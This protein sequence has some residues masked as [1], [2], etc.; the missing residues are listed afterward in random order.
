M[1]CEALSAYPKR[2]LAF[3]PPTAP[4]LEC[5]LM[6]YRGMPRFVALVTLLGVMHPAAAQPPVPAVI[7]FNRDIRP[8]LADNC[9]QCHGP[10]KNKRK[11][12]LRLDTGEGLFNA[13]DKTGPVV[14]GKPQESELLRRLT[15]ADANERMPDPK[16]GKSLSARQIA[17]L[18]K[19]IEQGAQWKDH[20]A[21]LKPVRVAAP[22]VDQPGFVTNAIDRW[23]LAKLREADLRPAAEADRVTLIR[24]LSFDLTGLPPTWP[25]VEAFVRDQRPDAYERLVDRLLASPAYGERMAVYWLDLVRYA[26]SIGYHS[27]NPMPVSPYRDYVIRSFNEN[28]PFDRFT[29]EQLAGDLLPQAGLDQKVA[30]AYNRLLQTTEEGGAQ[31]KEYEAK[32]AADRV[33]N[34]SAVWLAATMGCCQCHDHK[35]DPYATR[36]FYRLAAF[37]TDI[38][39]AAV[40]RREP[41]LSLSTPEQAAALQ[42]IEA[43]MAPLQKVLATPTAELEAS[44]ARW[45]DGL[46]VPDLR[47]LGPKLTAILLLEPA[48]RSPAQK[49]ELA[50]HYRGIAPELKP[51]RDRLAS[52]QRQKDGLE[53][54]IPRTLITVSGPPRTVRILP[55]GNWLDDSGEMVTPAA[56]PSLPPAL[57]NGPRATRLDLAHW[58]V[59]PE[60]PLTARVF[61]NRLWKLFFGQGLSKTLEDFGAQGEAPSHPELLDWLAVEFME[62]GWNVKHMVKLMVLSG[63]YRQSSHAAPD[64]KERDPYNRL[65]AHQARF[66][67]DAEMVRDNALAVSGLLVRRVGGPSVKPYQPPGYWAALNFP[68]REWQN[69]TGANL[70]RRGLY[71]HWQR[72]FLHPSLLAFD[73]PT[74]EE[75]VVERP[76]SNIPQQALALLNDPTYVEAA[77]TFAERILQEGGG[78][79]EQRLTWA[80]LCALSRKPRVSELQGLADL[81]QKHAGQFAADAASA[82]KLLGTGAHPL[83]PGMNRTELAAWTSVARVILNLHEFITRN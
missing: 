42:A 39:E 65:L 36:D 6:A 52:L 76:R 56:P 70:Y 47:K 25:E 10:D 20:W 83:A 62:S 50:A 48:K 7:D 4:P 23:V 73:A 37:F 27:D 12:H 69:D 5:S 64:A 14:P 35:F 68:P 66:R 51:A 31:A 38:K 43:Q 60:N 55:R 15:T 57:P 19:W 72:T 17:V 81:Y 75:C 28:K 33:R 53:K 1:S 61:T 67:L 54:A 18:K 58:I 26:D 30:S 44:Q 46:R 71:T 2:D 8:I 40:G 16:S 32:Y 45:E 41:G 80:Y 34:V 79:I 78:S 82:D 22:A 74:R 77:R 9:Y 11:A 63:T 24:R 49:Q 21:Y 3:R 29:V 59:S 13:R